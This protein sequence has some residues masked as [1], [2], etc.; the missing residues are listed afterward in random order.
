MLILGVRQF[1]ERRWEGV[2]GYQKVTCK[3][4]GRESSCEESSCE[5]T[6]TETSRCQRLSGGE[7]FERR[8]VSGP[9]TGARVT[10]APVLVFCNVAP[11]LG[12]TLLRRP[13]RVV[14]PDQQRTQLRPA[15]LAA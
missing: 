3:E 4:A 2:N 13:E 1:H 12:V 11:T 15:A 14:A 6:L 8:L 10:P 9:W 5:E 7:L